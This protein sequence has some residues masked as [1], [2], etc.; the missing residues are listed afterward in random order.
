MR[1]ARRKGTGLTFPD[2]A[3]AAGGDATE[4]GDAGGGAGESSLFF[5]TV[6]PPWN[7]LSRREGAATGKAP[8]VSRRPARPR[9]PLKS[10]A[11]LGTDRPRPYSYPHQVS[12]VRSLS[13]V[14]E[15]R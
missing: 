7:R 11:G 6:R 2:R 9:R 15:R 10:P 1:A 12:E 3:P 8:H 14:G 13:S 5:L 4:P